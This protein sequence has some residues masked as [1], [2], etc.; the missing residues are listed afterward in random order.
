[1]VANLDELRARV[2]V[3]TQAQAVIAADDNFEKA[4]IAL[5]RM[6]GLAPEQKIELTES[7]PYSQLQPMTIEAARAEAYANRQDYQM[8][9]QELRTAELERRATTHERFPT[10]NFNGNWGVTGVSG[11]IYHETFSAVGTM[12]VPIFEEARFRGDHDVAEA[13]LDQIRSRMQDLT[14]KIEQQLRDSLLDLQTAEQTVQVAK[15]NVDLASTAL[16]QTQQQFT[17]GVTDNLPV[18]EAQSTLA[19]AQTQY[20]GSVLQLNEARLG[21]ARNLGIIDTQYRSWLQGGSPPEV[22]S[23]AG[24]GMP[25]A[26]P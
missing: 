25:Q 14:V 8:M 16:D 24:A 5:T 7:A 11:G 1:V 10:I 18:A 15:S 20:V 26:L 23:N 6:I 4:K 9:K 2:Q 3:Q 21:F 12:S 22:K 13:Q 17:A 19:A